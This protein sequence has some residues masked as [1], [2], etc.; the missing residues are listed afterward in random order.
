MQPQQTMVPEIVGVSHLRRLAVSLVT[1]FHRVNSPQTFC[2][3]AP[4]AEISVQVRHRTPLQVHAIRLPARGR[5]VIRGTSP[6]IMRCCAWPRCRV[7]KILRSWTACVQLVCITR[8]SYARVSS[9][10]VTLLEHHR[11]RWSTSRG[12][13]RV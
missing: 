10:P 13:S 3:H 12:L 4:I 8:A 6:P 9:G 2:S 7:L 5:C 1:Y 11:V